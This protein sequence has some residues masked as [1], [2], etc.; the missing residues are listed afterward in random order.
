MSQHIASKLATVAFA[1]V[2]NGIVLGGI[3]YVVDSQTYAAP[4]SADCQSDTAHLPAA[5]V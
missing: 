2:M 4:T 1:M 3:C 5:I